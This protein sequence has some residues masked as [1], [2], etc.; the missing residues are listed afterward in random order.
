MGILMPA[1]RTAKFGV[2]VKGCVNP[3]ASCCGLNKNLLTAYSPTS[4]EELPESIIVS[5]IPK[6]EAA[7]DIASNTTNLAIKINYSG[8][9]QFNAQQYCE[10]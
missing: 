10:R 9:A 2:I 4:Y 6:A 5:G 8:V 7:R 3:A 1:S